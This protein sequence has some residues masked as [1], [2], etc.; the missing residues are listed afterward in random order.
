MY[1]PPFNRVSDPERAMAFLQAQTTA[2]LVTVI[3]GIPTATR[4]PVM[5]TLD[6]PT[7]TAGEVSSLPVVVRGHLAA[8]NPQARSLGDTAS[9]L[10][11]FD[12]PDGYVSPSNYGEK[13]LSGEVVPTWNYAAA[14]VT[15]PLS[16][17]PD[18]E[19]LMDFLHDLTDRHEAGRE[20]PWSV[21]DA[22]EPYLDR[23]VRGIVGV[24]VRAQLVEVKH[25]LSQN[26]PLDDQQRVAV[27]LLG[28]DH[29]GNRELGALMNE[30]LSNPN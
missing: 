2:Q 14:H 10:M 27:D 30:V 17:H 5:V 22:P 20:A 4:L 12:G 25:K 8:A 26:K 15:G 29:A 6:A 28:S 11:I 9:A 21:S 24:E 18:R 13:A 16:F 23:M 1:N 3:N 7:A 19:W